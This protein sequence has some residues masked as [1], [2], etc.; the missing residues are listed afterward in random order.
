[1]KSKNAEDFKDNLRHMVVLAENSHP[2]KDQP[3]KSE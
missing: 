3:M 2:P 1:V